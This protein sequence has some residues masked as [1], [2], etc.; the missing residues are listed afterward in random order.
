MFAEFCEGRATGFPMGTV[1]VSGVC[2]LTRPCQVLHSGGC[3][4]RIADLTTQRP[5]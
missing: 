5:L 1:V 3:L 4:G 2:A